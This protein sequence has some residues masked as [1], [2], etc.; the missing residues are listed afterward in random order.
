MCVA[1]VTEEMMAEA[2]VTVTNDFGVRIQIEHD[3]VLISDNHYVVSDDW[4]GDVLTRKVSRLMSTGQV[5]QTNLTIAS[6]YYEIGTPDIE[7]KGV[8]QM[9]IAEVTL[10]VNA[11]TQHKFEVVDSVTDRWGYTEKITYRESAKVRR[12]EKSKALAEALIH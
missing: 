7:V 6:D 1:A 9:T 2:K 4:Q 10:L 11:F 5:Y 3:D 12:E 8:G